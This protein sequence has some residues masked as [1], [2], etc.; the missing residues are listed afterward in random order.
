MTIEP[1]PGPVP[2]PSW[3]WRYL[4][5]DGQEVPIERLAEAVAAP[6]FAAQ[7]DA[8]SW[9]GEYWRDLLAAGVDSVALVVDGA[10]VY[11]PM[12]LHPAAD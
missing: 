8:E 7:A 10:A 12:S 9:V 11:G 5:S 2:A 6:R 3:S 4:D 1:L